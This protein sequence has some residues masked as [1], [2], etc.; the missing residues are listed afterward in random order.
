MR[1]PIVKDEHTLATA[2]QKGFAKLGFAVLHEICKDC[3]D[4]KVL[5]LS[6]RNE[7]DGHI[8]GLDQGANDYL[9]KPFAFSEP[10]A[11][12]RALIRC[13]FTQ[14]QTR[15]TYGALTLDTALKRAC[16]ASGEIPLTRKAYGI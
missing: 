16:D 6:A 13:T 14:G 9:G 12:V 5:I 4:A 11:R 3:Q 15:I 2:L 8:M 10:E 7:I 1:I